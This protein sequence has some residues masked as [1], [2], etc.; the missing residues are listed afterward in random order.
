ME[1]SNLY[2]WQWTA[3][4]VEAFIDSLRSA[5][6]LMAVSTA[7]NYAVELRLFLEYLTDPRYGWV[8]VCTDRFGAAPTQVLDEWNTVV[9]VSDYEGA[10]G[11]RPLSYEEVQRLFD[12][13]DDLVEQ[14][15]TGAAKGFWRPTGMRRC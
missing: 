2:P 8:Q 15:K 7:R 12:G 1:F 9:H 13:A 3:A 6:T 10:P 11:R 5:P 4:E 14:A